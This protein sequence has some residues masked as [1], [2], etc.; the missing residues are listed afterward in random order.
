MVSK[1]TQSNTVCSKLIEAIYIRLDMME[2]KMEGNVKLRPTRWEASTSLRD[3]RRIYNLLVNIA[4]SESV[5]TNRWN[6]LKSEIRT[7][8]SVIGSKLF[9]KL[10]SIANS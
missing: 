7:M 5:P 4:A 9:A 6:I 1:Q 8:S 3:T 10:D 2:S